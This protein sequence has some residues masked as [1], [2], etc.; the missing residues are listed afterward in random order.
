MTAEKR[1]AGLALIYLEDFD[2]ST[3]LERWQGLKHRVAQAITEAVAEE[4]ERL[5]KEADA[6][7]TRYPEIT[8]RWGE[9]YTAAMCEFAIAI[10][11]ESE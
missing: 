4:R 11:K 2:I 7:S 1:A 6:R 3:K 10:R 9:G 8:D 5:A